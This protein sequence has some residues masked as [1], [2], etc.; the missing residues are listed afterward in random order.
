MSKPTSHCYFDLRT[1]VPGVR[2]DDVEVER[3]FCDNAALVIRE[4]VSR[5]RISEALI[6]A[7]ADRPVRRMGRPRKAKPEASQSVPE[8]SAT[9]GPPPVEGAAQG[10]EQLSTGMPTA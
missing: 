9:Q 7:V 2:F 5:H 10:S 1:L 6:A 4:C 3:R 8:L